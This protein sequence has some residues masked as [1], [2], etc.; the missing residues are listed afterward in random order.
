MAIGNAPETPP[1]RPNLR[2]LRREFHVLLKW[3]HEHSWPLSGA[4]LL[5]SVIYLHHYLGAEQIPVS[6]A[7]ASAL[8]ALPVVLATVAFVLAVLVLFLL[9]PAFLL[10]VPATDDGRRLVDSPW[11][12]VN[13][14]WLVALVMSTAFVFLLAF[15]LS[16]PG[17]AWPKWLAIPGLL[18][19]AMAFL[20]VLLCR[21]LPLRRTTWEFRLVCLGTSLVQLLI[22]I[23]VLQVAAGATSGWLALLPAYVVAG[24]VTV[25]AMQV[26]AARYAAS[27]SWH[28]RPLTRAF[29]AAAMAL[30]LLALLPP[31][32]AP[33]AGYALQVSTTQGFSCV[34]PMWTAEAP[35]S[36]RRHETLRILFTD[37]DTWIA[38]SRPGEGKEALFVPRSHVV[39]L[40]PCPRDK[41][42][43]A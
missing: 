36:L 24:L 38:R 29:R 10:L 26:R 27:T 32:A 7:S 12:S 16:G 33:L 8:A 23:T 9:M 39:G 22:A 41:A 30:G 1:A 14:R 15:W 25:A 6:L 31:V 28:E 42:A 21:V 3:L 35:E 40:R 13:A 37:G 2:A 34:A 11:K 4:L 5:L 17:D 43:S 20:A 19:I 18:F